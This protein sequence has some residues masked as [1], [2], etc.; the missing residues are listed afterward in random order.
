MS[1][2]KYLGTFFS[3]QCHLKVKF[4]IFKDNLTFENTKVYDLEAP[5]GHFS[6]GMINIS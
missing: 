6:L 4:A 1:V 3:I 2:F 5:F